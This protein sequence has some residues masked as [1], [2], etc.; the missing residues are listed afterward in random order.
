[1]RSK[2]ECFW[3][4]RSRFKTFLSRV[5]GPGYGSWL[6]SDGKPWVGSLYS[7]PWADTSLLVS[8]STLKDYEWVAVVFWEET[9]QNEN[10]RVALGARMLTLDLTSFYFKFMLVIDFAKSSEG[11]F[12]KALATEDTLLRTHCCR[13]N[14]FPVCP[15]AQHLLRTQ[16]LCPG[17]KNVSDF[18]QKHFVPATNVSQFAQPEKYHGQ[19]CVLVCQGL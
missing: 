15:N 11:E 3:R 2:G 16:I 4:Q 10:R 6:G 13:Q 5:W 12:V 8:L 19:Q 18:V 7:V 17:Y 14:C 1:M 9:K